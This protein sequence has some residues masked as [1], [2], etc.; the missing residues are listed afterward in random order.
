[1][2]QLIKYELYKIFSRKYICVAILLFIALWSLN[3]WS[4][5]NVTSREIGNV[6]QYYLT[7]FKPFE[8]PVTAGKLAM[9]NRGMASWEKLPGNLTTRPER[10][11][12]LYSSIINT[13]DTTRTYSPI[14]SNRC[15]SWRI[16]T[17]WD[18]PTKS[19]G[20]SPVCSAG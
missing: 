7:E 19:S 3:F 18:T 8:G 14:Q 11:Y 5:A 9:A 16:N 13:H 2:C 6:R 15:A 1:M 17:I 4:E 20:W 12:I 10:P